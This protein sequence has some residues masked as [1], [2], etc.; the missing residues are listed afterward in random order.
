MNR[1]L[2][3]T[4]TLL[5]WLMNSEKIGKKAKEAISDPDHQVYISAASIWEITIKKSIGKLEAPD[6]MT[7]IV[8]K[9]GFLQLPITL[10]HGESI[11]NLPKIHKDPFDRMLIIQAQQEN[12]VIITN[13]SIIPQYKVNTTLASE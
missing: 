4:H 5:W 9:K 6:N 2:L 1:F 13:D 8:I 10:F 11:R 3:D 7:N 12:L